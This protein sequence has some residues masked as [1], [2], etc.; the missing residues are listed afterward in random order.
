MKRLYNGDF[1]NSD[2]SDWVTPASASS[3]ETVAEPCPY[4]E[5]SNNSLKFTPGAN[6]KFIRTNSKIPITEDGEYF[7]ET[8]VK[9]SAAGLKAKLALRITYADNTVSTKGNVNV[10]D[11]DWVKIVQR[12]TLSDGDQVEIRIVSGPSGFDTGAYLLIDDIIMTHDVTIQNPNGDWTYLNNTAID[13]NAFFVGNEDATMSVNTDLNY[14]KRGKTSTK[15]DALSTVTQSPFN[16]AV[17]STK[18]DK[19]Y[20]H[21]AEDRDYRG[22]CWVYATGASKMRLT[23]YAGSSFAD[24]QI[25]IN[26]NEWTNIETPVF[27]L[28]STYSG[29]VNL[30]LQI[31][32]PNVSVYVDNV[33]LSYSTSGTGDG[34][35]K[36]G[37]PKSAKED[38]VITSNGIE[39]NLDTQIEIYDTLM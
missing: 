16:P 33:N 35:L 23:G 28:P 21:P 6:A 36:I 5:G 32:T 17:L 3:E 7:F 8:W 39:V 24:Q 29:K 38:V 25:D 34:I 15:L 27:N 18:G 1:E 19:A 26:A 12:Q 10:Y 2:L 37:V 4:E 20:S 11:D 13:L 9:A 30:K 31:L 22:H 14:V